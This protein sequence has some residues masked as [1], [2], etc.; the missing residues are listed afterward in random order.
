[1]QLF[2]D[3]CSSSASLTGCASPVTFSALVRPSARTAATRSIAV[4]RASTVCTKIIASKAMAY[5]GRLTFMCRGVPCRSSLM[6]PLASITTGSPFVRASFSPFSP[7]AKE[8]FPRFITATA[9]VQMQCVLYEQRSPSSSCSC[10]ASGL[11]DRKQNPI[12]LEQRRD[13]MRLLVLGVANAQVWEIMLQTVW[14]I[15]IPVKV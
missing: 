11:Q 7:S 3:V 15:R 2:F 13:R 8:L 10:T 6:P 1:M 9:S 4:S 12:A 5:I 14:K